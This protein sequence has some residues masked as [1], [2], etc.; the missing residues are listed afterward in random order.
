MSDITY[1]FFF[2][3]GVATFV[4]VKFGRKLGYSGGNAVWILTGAVFVVMFLVFLSIAKFFIPT[5]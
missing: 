3:A 2:A 1:S 5:N 4:Y